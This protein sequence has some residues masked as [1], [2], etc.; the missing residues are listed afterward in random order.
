ME[1]ANYQFLVIANGNLNDGFATFVIPTALLTAGGL[2]G[3]S[4]G[5]MELEKCDGLIHSINCTSNHNEVFN[6]YGISI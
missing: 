4:S 5:I 3:M 2:A 1:F 6:K